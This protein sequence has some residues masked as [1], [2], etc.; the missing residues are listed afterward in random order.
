MAQCNFLPSEFTRDQNIQP[1]ALWDQF[2]SDSVEQGFEESGQ[3]Y[4]IYQDDY[5]QRC[6][7]QFV[8]FDRDLM[9]LKSN[10]IKMKFPNIQD[11][12]FSRTF[13][14]DKHG[15][16]VVHA[17]IKYSKDSEGHQQLKC[18]DLYYFCFHDLLETKN[19]HDIFIE[20]DRKPDLSLEYPDTESYEEVKFDYESRDRGMTTLLVHSFNRFPDSI[21]HEDTPKRQKI[22]S[23]CRVDLV[24]SSKGKIW[25]SKKIS[26]DL[27]R[28]NTNLFLTR[29]KIYA[30]GDVEDMV[31]KAYEFDLNGDYVTSYSATAPDHD[32]HILKQYRNTM[33]YITQTEV[34]HQNESRPFQCYRV[35]KFKNGKVEVLA[36]WNDNTNGDGLPRDFSDDDDSDC[37]F[38]RF[39]GI[40]TR[41]GHLLAQYRID[42][43]NGLCEF[44]FIN[45]KTKDTLIKFQISENPYLFE[46]KLNLSSNGR[47]FSSMYH[48]DQKLF[49]VWKI[50]FKTGEILLKKFARLAVLTSFSEVYLI[51][52][53]LPKSLFDYLGIEK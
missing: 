14:F 46:G 10:L 42:R 29:D 44:Q 22:C 4:L 7:L 20:E 5:K 12:N 24:Q 36:E 48:Y 47:E 28:S 40:L 49:K 51:Q 2:D 35:L 26:L 11:R 53:N 33:H 6:F 45:L 1:F 21:D 52:Q 17:I 16:Q 13:S 43:G 23:E 3:Y 27:S 8:Y 25:H 37:V 18:I 39:V 50:D 9:T 38:F 32:S 15:A 31:F 30:Y 41:L 19:D 34:I